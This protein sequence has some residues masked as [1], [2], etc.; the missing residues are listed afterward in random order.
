MSHNIIC[1]SEQKMQLKQNA[2]KD[3]FSLILPCDIKYMRQSRETPQ[4][5]S[6]ITFEESDF[7]HPVWTVFIP[8]YLYISQTVGE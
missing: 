1:L 6:G 7:G 8:V 5:F 3:D 2:D 4:S